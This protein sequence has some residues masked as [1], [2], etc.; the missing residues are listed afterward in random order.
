MKRIL[1]SV[2][3]FLSFVG[4]AFGADQKA[5]CDGF[6][7]GYVTGY[8]QASQQN[9]KPLLPLC[10]LEPMKMFS[11]PQNDFEFGYLKGL[12]TGRNVFN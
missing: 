1:Y 8:K 2:L 7:A 9:L 6:R 10:P 11:D 3:I 12:T 5:F 4:S